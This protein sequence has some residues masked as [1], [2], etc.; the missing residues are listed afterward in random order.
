MRALE[1]EVAEFGGDT[2]RVYLTGISMGGYGAWHLA[3][4]HPEKFAALVVVCGGVLPP[5]QGTHAV[6]QAPETIGARDPYARAAELAQGIPC[7][8]FHGDDDRVIPVTESRL[9]HTALQK[10]GSPVRYTEYPG[11][12]HGCWDRAYGEPELWTWLPSQKLRNR[13]GR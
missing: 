3:A 4:L 11:V 9:M 13:S 6:H 10:L 7:W 2:S 1:R 12:N 5:T 8:I